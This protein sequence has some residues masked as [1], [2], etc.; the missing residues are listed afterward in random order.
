MLQRMNHQQAVDAGIWQRQVL[1]KHQCCRARLANRPVDGALAC[2]HER[3]CALTVCLEHVQIRGRIS[4][5]NQPFV[6]DRAPKNRQRLTDE[7][8]RM[9]TH[10]C[11]IKLAEVDYVHMHR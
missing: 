5:T 7:P 1:I 2:G 3:E 9:S 6:S 4:Q 11:G 10:G 8:A